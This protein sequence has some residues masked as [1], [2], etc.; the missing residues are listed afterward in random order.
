MGQPERQVLAEES[1]AANRGTSR[2]A[3]P[4]AEKSLNGIHSWQTVY[5]AAGPAQRAELLALAERQGLLY[6]HQLP[7]PTNGRPLDEVRQFLK[8][9]LT[10]A[11]RDIAPIRVAP[12][13]APGLNPRQRE[14]VARALATPD[15]CLIQGFP[16]TGKSTT[17]AEIVSHAA[18]RGES[19][20]VVS[21]RAAGTDRI[22]D[23]TRGR[24]SVCPV[25]F[26]GRNERPDALPEYSRS[27]VFSEQLRRLQ[28]QAQS[29]ADERLAEAECRHAGVAA[30]AGT[31]PLLLELADRHERL[32][33]KSRDSARQRESI[34]DTVALI[35]ARLEVSGSRE[36]PEGASPDHDF[37]RDILAGIES[38]TLAQTQ[39]DQSLAELAHQIQSSK[40]HL[41]RLTAEENALAP[42][43]EAK[44]GGR[45][46]KWAWWW[47]A[48]HGNVAAQAADLQA[49]ILQGR[50]ELTRVEDE[51]ARFHSERRHWEEKSRAEQAGRM[52]REVARRIAEIDAEESVVTA[53]LSVLDVK[54][55]ELSDRLHPDTPRCMPTV[56]DVRTAMAQWQ[57][58]SDAASQACNSS[59]AW[60]DTLRQDPQMLA[61]RLR[62]CFNVVA[63]TL[64][65]SATDPPC[66]GFGEDSTFD[67]LLIEHAESITEAEFVAAARRCRRWVL[68]AESTSL[69]SEPP[70]SNS[71][72]GYRPDRRSNKST[73]PGLF[74]R[75]WTA[76]HCDPS[77]LPYVWL[78]EADNRLCCR[79]RSVSAEQRRWLEIERV[80][81]F[82]E[83]ELRIVA[84]PRG[85]AGG[86]DSFLA[87]VVFPSTMSIADAKAYIFRELDEVPVRAVGRDVEWQESSDRLRMLLTPQYGESAQMLTI[88]LASG[89]H[90]LIAGCPDGQTADLGWYTAA[91]EFEFAAGW[92][93]NRAESWAARHLGMADL[94]RTA[95]LTAPCGFTS[96]L[97]AFLSDVLLGFSV[98]VQPSHTVS[99]GESSVEFT[100]V[101]SLPRGGPRPG[102]HGARPPS[103]AGLE[104]DL[105]DSRHR[106]RLPAEVRAR[107]DAMRGYVNFAEAQ[108]VVRALARM[109]RERGSGRTLGRISAAG[110]GSHNGDSLHPV[111]VGVVALYPGQAQLIRLLLEPEATALAA[112]GLEIRVDAPGGFHEAECGIALVSLT[113][114]HVHRAAVLGDGPTALATALTRGRFRLMV[115]G[116]VGTLARRVEWQAPLDHLDEAAGELERGMVTRLLRY[117][118]GEGKSQHAFRLR[119][120]HGFTGVAP[121]R[122]VPARRPVGREGSN[123]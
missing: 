81:D 64:T 23:L 2:R 20:L 11:A 41:A 79:L 111:R 37:E 106:D 72:A 100:A 108:A 62:C 77:R 51:S 61:E 95:L 29:A 97:S 87:E 78:R 19:V 116:D 46:W 112:A 32:L 71:S 99:P 34:P 119:H 123:A 55:R 101:P 4:T 10:S 56:A 45:W 94:G 75:L 121:S 25:R 54:R 57:Q 68:I 31:W 1:H 83:I 28:S 109:A 118:S 66:D 90:E 48:F 17:A 59:R 18:E 6:W 30:D 82:R 21:P 102:R 49:R 3:P 47:A 52:E 35:V 65:G 63:A 115:F 96:G 80:A 50:E 110:I 39:I 42:L 58:L 105:S 14:A 104:I 60:A 16:A 33:E 27:L 12:I 89:V 67:L 9:V 120:D 53:A 88:P 91:L 74:K 70:N 98:R 15:I 76:L 117:I 113:R 43:A 24:P 69:E 122:G 5:Q 107:I 44:A 22:L 40:E 86:A 8:V 36:A 85:N 38:R 93:R 103:G 7:R 73:S 13:D 92:D 114:S 84:P 26:L